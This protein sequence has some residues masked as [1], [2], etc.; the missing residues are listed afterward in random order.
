MKK[1]FNRVFCLGLLT[2]C[3]NDEIKDL[4]DA[5]V[6]STI[7]ATGQSAKELE[8]S[9][10]KIR[11]E[12]EARELA[13]KESATSLVFDRLE[14]N[15]GDTKPD[16]ENKTTFKVTNTGNKPLVIEDVAASCGC[17]TP[18]KPEAPIAP[19]KSDVIEVVFK[20]SQGQEGVQSKTVTVTANTVEKIHK[21]EI[22]AN[23]K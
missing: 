8:A 9:L 7:S 16:V 18:K 6:E 19:G 23:V 4:R 17:T 10:E 3:A 12:E 21:L 5:E 14:H 13:I 20:A 15:F 11:Q 2:A 1:Y 22:R